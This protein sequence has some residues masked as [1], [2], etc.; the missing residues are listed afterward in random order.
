MKKAFLGIF[1]LLFLFFTPKTFAAEN[2]ST[3]YNVTYS[4]SSNADTKV[5]IDVTLTN[6]SN[7]YYA[8]SYDIEVGFKDLRDISTQQ[9]SDKVSST[10]IK[11]ENGSK[12]H[13]PFSQKVVGKDNKLNFKVTFNTKEIAQNLE[14]VWDINIPG[15][16]KKSDF[17]NF[18]VAVIYPSFLGP[19]AYIKPSLPHVL[20]NLSGNTLNFTR[21]D[22]GESGISLAFGKFQIYNFD[23]TYH[24]QNTN[25]FSIKTELSLPPTTNYQDVQIEKINPKP[26]NVYIDGDG[27][28]LAQYLLNASQKL[29]VKVNGKAKV[30]LTPRTEKVSK[31][32]LDS[33]LK[34]TS[35]WESNEPK[36]KKLSEELKTPKAIYNYV[37]KTLKYD[38]SRIETQSPRLGALG[39]LGK[40]DSAVCLEFTDLFIALTRSAGIPA[41]A[42]NGYAYTENER[43]RPLSFIKDVLHAWPEY[44]DF[45]SSAWVMVDPTWGNTTNGVDYFNVLDFDHFAFVK[46]GIKSSYPIPAGGYKYSGNLNVKD[47]NISISKD[48]AKTEKNLVPSIEISENNIAGFPI[49][50][51]VRVENRSGVLSNSLNAYVYSDNFTPSYQNIFVPVIPPFGKVILDFAFNKTDIL[52]NEADTIRISLDGKSAYKNIH[53]SPVFLD[54]WFILGGVL[55]VIFITAIPITYSGLRRISLFRQKRDNNLR[56]EGDKPTQK[57]I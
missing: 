8:S 23:L 21:D 54:K 12:I 41:R 3:D 46:N 49:K 11:T 1:I 7:N 19:L 53:I 50:G 24:M 56:G 22:L 4:I 13:V 17:S 42:V 33:Y 38:F 14:N 45:D 16:S 6:L 18:K 40:P 39:A 27:N 9:E 29:D 31:K 51:K 28:W 32:D 37:V 26:L 25:L 5:N 2:F 52:T 30:Y 36:I 57:S 20:E 15:I 43:Q 34:Q 35:F 55:I 47:V 10:I 48:F 44:Y